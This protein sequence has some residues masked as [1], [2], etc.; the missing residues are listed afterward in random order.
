MIFQFRLVNL[1]DVAQ[2]DHENIW[3]ITKLVRNSFLDEDHKRDCIKNIITS[4]YIKENID[5]FAE[6]LKL[7]PSPIP[8]DNVSSEALEIAADIFTYLN[9]CPPKLIFLIKHILEAEK[10]KDIILAFTSIMKTSDK[11]VKES[12]M[13]IFL[14]IMESFKLKQ[15]EKVQRITKGKCFINGTFG[16]CTN[17]DF[18]ED[19]LKSLGLF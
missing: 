1:L 14:K 3:R 18:S 16:N 9:F 15:H 17:T 10:P 19:D 4:N 2:L 11:K 7:K 8:N 5:N 13:K 6:E 12:S